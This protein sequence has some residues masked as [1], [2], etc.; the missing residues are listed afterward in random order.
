MTHAL[1]F[2]IEEAATFL[3]PFGVHAHILRTV[4]VF[5]EVGLAGHITAVLVVGI[6]NP[7]LATL[8][9]DVHL[10]QTSVEADGRLAIVLCYL[11]DQDTALRGKDD[12]KVTPLPSSPS[13]PVAG[14]PPWI[15]TQ[16]CVSF[17]VHTPVRQAGAFAVLPSD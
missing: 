5:N 2:L 9:L 7:L 12:V 1:Q 16:R 4:L 6:Q 8:I 15:P 13:P 17:G 14:H 3:C 10:L 11:C